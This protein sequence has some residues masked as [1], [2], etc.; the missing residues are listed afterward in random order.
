MDSTT[1]TI[2]QGSNFSA[3]FRWESAAF[4]SKA[5]S[6]VTKASPAVVTATAHGI[7]N[8]WWVWNLGYKG[9]TQINAEHDETD[10]TKLRT[11]ERVQATL[12]DANS[13]SFNKINS[14]NYSTYTSGGILAWHTPNSLAGYFARMQIRS[15]KESTTVLSTFETNPAPG[16]GVGN[17]R[18]ALDDTLKTITVAMT[19]AETAAF[20]DAWDGAEWDLEMVS[21]AGTVTRIAQG[22][23]KISKEV[24]R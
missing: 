21:G 2:K 6:A 24:T 7:P 20:D 8:G 23:I 3:I 17:G 16:G 15:S 10:F 18:I 13:V 14:T 19:A 1:L 12:V 11:S 5:V 22:R 9:M 4:S